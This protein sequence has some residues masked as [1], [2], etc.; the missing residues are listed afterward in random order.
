MLIPFPADYNNRL[1]EFF[2]WLMEECE[3]EGSL[4]FDIRKIQAKALE[5]DLIRETTFR[6]SAGYGVFESPAGNCWVEYS[7]LPKEE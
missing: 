4:E 2:E 7:S 5:L 6:K 3:A 1:F